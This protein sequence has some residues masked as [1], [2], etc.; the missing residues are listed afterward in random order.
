MISFLFLRFDTYFFFFRK[1]ESDGERN[2]FQENKKLCSNEDVQPQP[3]Q[4]VWLWNIV[5]GLDF[6]PKRFSPPINSGG[7]SFPSSPS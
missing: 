4:N 2:A 1:T 3:P 7:L 6:F 5:K